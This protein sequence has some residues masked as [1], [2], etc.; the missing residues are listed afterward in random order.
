MSHRWNWDLPT[1]FPASKCAPHP[2]T[3]EGVAHSLADEELGEPQFQR[4]EK[5]LSILCSLWWEVS[6]RPISSLLG[7]GGGGGVRGFPLEMKFCIMHSQDKEVNVGPN[8]CKL[9]EDTEY[10]VKKADEIPRYPW[11]HPFRIALLIL[12]Y[13]AQC[14]SW[15]F[16]LSS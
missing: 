13:F 16:S 6:D 8:L 1:P 15:I 4:P 14:P 3:K 9:C 2:R 10:T 5:K 12:E 7:V 11:N